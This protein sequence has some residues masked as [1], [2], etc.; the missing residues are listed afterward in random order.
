[1]KR[2]KLISG[3]KAKSLFQG[4]LLFVVTL[5]VGTF[6]RIAS[7]EDMDGN[8][9]MFAT[10]LAIGLI[11]GLSFF[12]QFVVDLCND[13]NSKWT[14]VNYLIPGI[15]LGLILLVFRIP[16]EMHDIL[17]LIILFSIANL[18]M[19]SIMKKSEGTHSR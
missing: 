7:E 9:I 11:I 6:F 8:T 15:L 14:V 16:V 19:Y 18:L 13:L 5:T 17:L 3:E 1:M 4:H 10:I 12:N 2:R